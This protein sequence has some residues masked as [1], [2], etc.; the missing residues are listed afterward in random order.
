MMITCQSS[1]H[2]KQLMPRLLDAEVSPQLWSHHHYY[3][4]YYLYY[5]LHQKKSTF[6]K[7]NRTRHMQQFMA[8]QWGFMS[9]VLSLL[10]L[11]VISSCVR[12]LWLAQSCLSAGLKHTIILNDFV[13]YIKNYWVNSVPRDRLLLTSWKHVIEVYGPQYHV[14]DLWTCALS[15]WQYMLYKRFYYPKQ[16]N[17][18]ICL[19]GCREWNNISIVLWIFS[20]EM[21]VLL[22]WTTH[23]RYLEI[24]Q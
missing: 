7:W 23:S 13:V 5:W 14:T 3:G 15:I 8:Y 6:S 1:S 16:V 4:I 21:I 17:T 18:T 11:V 9:L 12:I 19:V 2:F 22:R 20:F 10:L 24:S